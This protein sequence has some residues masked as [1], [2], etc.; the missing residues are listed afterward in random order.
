MSPRAGRTLK[1]VM[2]GDTQPTVVPIEFV[3]DFRKAG[4]KFYAPHGEDWIPPPTAQEERTLRQKG[5]AGMLAPAGAIGGSI[6]GGTTGAVLGAPG[7]PPGIAA[8]AFAGRQVG[9]VLGGGLGQALTEGVYRAQGWGDAPGTV[10]GEMGNQ[11]VW[12]PVG[13][14]AMVPLQIGGRLLLR[15]SLPLRV[16]NTW[17][18]IQEM[19]RERLPVGGLPDPRVPFTSIAVKIPRIF[20]EGSK[21]SGENVIAKTA[22]RDAANDAAEAA[23]TT[24]SRDV[25]AKE[26]RAMKFD[27]RKRSDRS[28]QLAARK[29]RMKDF[30][31]AWRRGDLSPNDAQKF[32]SSLDEEANQ[33]WA[34][35]QKRGV[36][37]VPEAERVKAQQ[38]RRLARRIREEMRANVPGHQETSARLSGAIAADD[39]ISEAEKMGI[40]KVVGRTVAGGLTGGALGALT[41]EHDPNIAARAALVG[42]IL[43]HPA[44]ASRIGL[45][46]AGGTLGNS[47]RQAPRL[48]GDPT[49]LLQLL[50]LAKPDA[51]GK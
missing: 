3:N 6:A 35:E 33:L 5:M 19:A 45:S 30:Y 8:G 40:D 22:A 39:A 9:G 36:A 4:A 31:D 17:K 37:H 48:M 26:G 24:I 15:T 21:L 10:M 14:A 27:Y 38:A 12:G 13:E 46:M 44:V 42:A 23:G 11:A 50:G 34:A 16:Q 25:G 2:P 32:L 1:M 20:R 51:T 28:T 43:G 41:P 29:K 49:Y 47:V 7:G 18:A